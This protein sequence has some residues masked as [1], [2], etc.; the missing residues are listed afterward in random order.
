MKHISLLVGGRRQ[1]FGPLKLR[2]LYTNTDKML[3]HS[4]A[5]PSDEIK[6]IYYHH[7][8][9]YQYR[10]RL[11][12]QNILSSLRPYIITPPHDLPLQPL[13][14]PK[15]L[16]HFLHSTHNALLLVDFCGWTSKLLPKLNGTHITYTMHGKP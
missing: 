2:Y 7:S 4:I 8:I 14:T 6:L 10:G 5:P 9:S 15:Q 1:D 11:R 13:N 12:P 3:A 16:T